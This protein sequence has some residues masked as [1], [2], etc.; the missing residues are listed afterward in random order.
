MCTK[1]PE[2][3]KIRIKAGSNT[4][5]ISNILKKYGLNTVC[6]EADCPNTCECFN[7]G[8][9]T[10]MILGK[11]CTRNCKFCKVTKSK[12]EELDPMEPKNIAKAIQEM[13][14]KHTVITSV[15]R[16]DLPDGGAGHF[17]N[18]ILEIKKLCPK[19]TVEVLIPD[20]KGDYESL[21]KVV[22][23]KPNVLN[24]NVET[25]PNLYSA[26][27]PMAVYKRSL[28]LLK[29]VKEIDSSIF[30]KSGFMV[31]L[32]ENEDQVIELLKDL[33]KVNCDIITIG[34]YLQPSKEHYEV[35]EY[36]HPDK[37]KKYEKI[38]K[39]MGFKFVA[40]GPL[41]RSSYHAEDELSSLN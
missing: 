35:V 2:W 6:A 4:G 22:Y 33:K 39:G 18:T 40:S 38:A 8:T 29:R 31:G 9:A 30:T 15:T 16:D 34:Q 27:R 24:H 23:A 21:K 1:K 11:N 41:V 25:I 36:V 32:G 14:L 3:L 5:N 7:R 10:F 13:N 12:P 19:V 28:E 20:L 17:A 37:F 26:V